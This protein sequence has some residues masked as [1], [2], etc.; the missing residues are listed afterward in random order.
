MSAPG[1]RLPPE[2]MRKL[3]ESKRDRWLRRVELLGFAALLLILTAYAIGLVRAE[4]R[5]AELEGTLV[6][7]LP[8]SFVC[9]EELR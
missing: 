8:G 6:V 1:M 2:M 5:C 3:F 7:G 4:K 9:V